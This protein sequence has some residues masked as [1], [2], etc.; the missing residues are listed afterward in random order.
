M[1]LALTLTVQ[2]L[3]HITKVVINDADG[4]TPRQATGTYITIEAPKLRL[5]GHHCREVA[6]VLTEELSALANLFQEAT[7]L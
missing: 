2:H 6:Q 4:A 3:S 1:Y 5:G 7:I